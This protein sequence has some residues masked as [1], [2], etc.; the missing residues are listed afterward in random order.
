MSHGNNH[1]TID[2]QA[3]VLRLISK[4]SSEIFA[5]RE[6]EHV[7]LMRLGESAAAI[8]SITDSVRFGAEARAAGEAIGVYGQVRRH[9]GI[10]AMSGQRDRN[11]FVK[12][13][14]TAVVNITGVLDKAEGDVTDSTG[15]A[16]GT[17]YEGIV[18]K[19]NAA[20]L[21]QTISAIV[22]NVDSPGGAAMSVDPAYQAVA[23]AAKKKPVIAYANDLM[24]SAALYVAVGATE[25]YGSAGSWIGS[26]GTVY[27][28]QNVAAY[29]KQRGVE[30]TVVSSNPAKTATYPYG[31]LSELGKSL[32]QGE[33]DAYSEMFHAAVMNGRGM[34]RERL[35]VARAKSG[36][37][38]G[39]AMAVGLADGTMGSLDAVIRYAQSLPAGYAAAAGEKKRLQAAVADVPPIAAA[40]QRLPEHRPTEILNM[41][42]PSDSPSSSSSALPPLPHGPIASAPM[43]TVPVAQPTMV[44]TEAHAQ[45]QG[46]AAERERVSTIMARC[47]KFTGNAKV[48]ALRDSAIASGLTP[49]QFS[50]KAM[51]VLSDEN[52]PT[53]H[54]PDGSTSAGGADIGIGAEQADKVRHIES[55]ALFKRINSNASG[56]L[57]DDSTP[58]AKAAAARMARSLGC[59]SPNKALALLESREVRPLSLQ[60]MAYRAIARAKRISLEQAMDSY[61]IENQMGFMAALT[62]T[63]SDFPLILE[64][65]ANKTLMNPLTEAELVWANF[66]RRVVAN[67]YKPVNLYGLSEAGNLE[68]IPETKRPSFTTFN[69]RKQ[70]V[71]VAAAGRRLALTYQMI[72]NDD[73]GAFAGA[74]SAMAMAAARYP[75]DLFIAAL[76]S[77]SGLGPTMSDG[78][79]L[80]HATHNN[81]GTGAALSYNAAKADFD[82]MSRQVGFGPDKVPLNIEP[83]RVLVPTQLRW[84]AQDIAGQKH[85][86]DQ[87][88]ANGILDNQLYGR[89]KVLATS[90]LAAGTT[91]RWWFTSPDR[92]PA[93]AMAFLDGQE[94]PSVTTDPTGDP[95]SVSYQVT[96]PGVGLGVVQWEGAITNAGV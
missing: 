90:R 86:P 44:F 95:L 4:A 19:V 59:D 18:A 88:V 61:P 96:L 1:N 62:H 54:V 69:E 13:G 39:A 72:R 71:S 73:L 17:S 34:S 58:A 31:P 46:A 30:H 67:D 56:V 42:L 40:T 92:Y 5:L 8:S 11:S 82:T 16:F 48:V 81:I 37:V 38:G 20:V 7:E 76:T 66:C 91:R 70:T 68:A 6:Q 12:M 64:A 47:T 9:D 80:F 32:L 89:F 24:A 63:T 93:F 29:Y 25:I 28:H 51:D 3:P 41:P 49:D 94:M 15:H 55:I 52:K 77:N 14:N 85:W 60:R 50:A 23:E 83:D 27:V 78:L 43:Q 26:I 57:S 35:D 74:A 10:Y 22:L 21:D 75:E 84:T 65:A 2:G 53:G 33:V 79:T 87:T 36:H 45:A